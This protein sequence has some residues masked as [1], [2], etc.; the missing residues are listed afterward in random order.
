MK[1]YVKLN[2]LAE[3]LYTIEYTSFDYEYAYKFMHSR[4]APKQVGACSAVYSDNGL[5]GK[6]FDWFYSTDV[7][8]V[9]INRGG[10][11]DTIGVAGAVPTLNKEFVESGEDSDMYKILP[12][13]INDGMNNAGVFAGLNVVPSGDAGKT[14]GTNPT[15][16]KP[17][18]SAM[19]LPRYVLDRCGSAKEAVWTIQNLNIYCPHNDNLEE[20]VHL[21]V[22][23]IHNQYLIEFI[24]NKT[25]VIELTEN[26]WI[27]NYYRYGAE[28]L[29]DGHLDWQT[30]TPH[31]NGTHRS[32]IIADAFAG[33]T[34]LYVDDLKV[35]MREKLAY[36]NMYTDNAWMDELCADYG[37]GSYGDLT[38]SVLHNNPS[39]FNAVYASAQT[40][41]Q[42]R[43]RD[44]KKTWQTCHS[45]IYDIEALRLN[46]VVDE[47][48]V[49][50]DMDMTG[51]TKPIRKK[52]MAP[53]GGLELD[54]TLFDVK[55]DIDGRSI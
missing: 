35:L 1:P 33:N 17:P 53:C 13:L 51:S 11:Y 41:Y 43:E 3:Y 45:N 32:D 22:G 36:T 16:T 20:E 19:M 21:I 37:A 9:V 34:E 50:F 44:D 18:V 10:N 28:F 49:E 47:D 52:V 23:D 42:N 30:L 5:F 46:V 31:A 24:N 8:F 55:E 40:R 54:E 6:N 27:T 4:Y 2:R 25:V 29:A 26:K 38:Q 39:A 15:S 14:T 12:F 7:E 48:G